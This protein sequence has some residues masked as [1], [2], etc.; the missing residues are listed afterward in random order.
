MRCS[1]R[2][3]ESRRRS[4]ASP[5]MYSPTRPPRSP[6]CRRCSP[7]CCS[8]GPANNPFPGKE[9]AHGIVRQGR[10]HASVA[11]AH[12]R[13]VLL[14]RLRVLGRREPVDGRAQ[15]RPPRRPARGPHECGGGIME[16]AGGLEDPA[17]HPKYIANVQTCRGSHTHT[18]VIDP[19]DKDNVYVYVS[20]SAPVRSPSELPGCVAAPPDSNP[21]SALFRIEVIKVPLAH[22]EQAA[23]LSSP[24]R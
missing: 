1:S 13:I 23:I 3:R 20:G 24:D 15:P 9:S 14:R 8:R 10:S 2:E 22:P 5:R 12:H 6:A 19:N 4:S 11:G 17:A 18:V 21:N 16:S 7:R